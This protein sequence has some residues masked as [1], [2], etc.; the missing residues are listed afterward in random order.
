MTETDMAILYDLGRHEV[1]DCAGLR[2]GCIHCI[3]E[4]IRDLLRSGVTIETIQ[5]R[6]IATNDDSGE[7]VSDMIGDIR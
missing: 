5:A 7:A 2:E 4:G 1:G 6:I 3:S